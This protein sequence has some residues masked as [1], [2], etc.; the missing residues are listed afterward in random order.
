LSEE[1][2]QESVRRQTESRKKHNEDGRKQE[3]GCGKKVRGGG[4]QEERKREEEKQEERKRE[5]EKQEWGNR[6]R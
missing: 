6:N 5:E 1:G 3:L 4:K 2:N